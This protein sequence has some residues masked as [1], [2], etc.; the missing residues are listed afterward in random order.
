MTKRPFDW[1]L[2]LLS[3]P[4]QFLK[5][6]LWGV[7]VKVDDVRIRTG[8]TASVYFQ[9]TPGKP[10]FARYGGPEVDSLRFKQRIS[11]DKKTST[12]A[13]V[14]P[15]KWNPLFAEDFD[16]DGYKN[17]DDNCPFRSNHSQRDSDGDRV[18]NECDNASNVKNF[19]QSDLDFDHVGDLVDN[20]R[21]IYNPDQA[22]RDGDNWG[23]ACDNAHAKESVEITPKHIKIIAG[24]AV[25]LLVGFGVF[26]VVKISKKKS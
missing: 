15:E 20:C 7:N 6:S 16:D 8:R 1:R 10:T 21:L 25:L 18:G 2:D 9:A 24:A 3:E 23:D 14:G 26:T 5:I 12:I 19:N 22:D 13:D 11:S 17:S 4:A